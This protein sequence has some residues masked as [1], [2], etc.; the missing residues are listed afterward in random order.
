MKVLLIV[1]LL[2]VSGCAG[3]PTASVI[4][5]AADVAVD[6]CRIVVEAYDYTK[7]GKEIDQ[8]CTDAE[9]LKP[10][11]TEADRFLRGFEDYPQ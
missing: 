8:Y 6:I 7:K 2:T 4:A 10:Y 1:A 9:N 11:I 5:H 3:F